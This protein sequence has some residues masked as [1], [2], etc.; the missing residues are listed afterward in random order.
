[1]GIT[2]LYDARGSPDNIYTYL[3]HIAASWLT[4]SNS[5]TNEVT[6]KNT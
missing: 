5:R 6:H 2:K 3:N 1:M 4:H